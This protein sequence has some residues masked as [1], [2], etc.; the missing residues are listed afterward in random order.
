[1][2]NTRCVRRT[3]QRRGGA[4]HPPSS[5]HTRAEHSVRAE[6]APYT[7]L[8]RKRGPLKVEGGAVTFDLPAYGLAAI[9]LIP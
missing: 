5:S 1:V 9:K 8:E 4:L 3:H 2:P 7:P 6:H